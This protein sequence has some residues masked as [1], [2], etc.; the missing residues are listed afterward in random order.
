MNLFK[1]YIDNILP[2]DGEVINNGVI[3]NQHIASQYFFNLIKTIEWRHDELL[4][5]GKHIRTKKKVAWYGDF[6]VEYT[7]SNKTKKAI[8]R[9]SE[10]VEF[11]KK[12]KE[13]PRLRSILAY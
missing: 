8:P 4:I 9:T 12:L 3:M 6:G 7:Y 11:K 5:F 1:T 2:F 13:L 10:L